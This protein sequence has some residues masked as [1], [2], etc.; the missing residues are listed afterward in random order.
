MK[1]P[2]ELVT[3]SGSSLNTFKLII[4]GKYHTHLV[5]VTVCVFRTWFVSAVTHKCCT[6]ETW[7]EIGT[8]HV[9]THKYIHM[10]TPFLL[11]S[12][13]LGFDYSSF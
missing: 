9:C 4:E 6:A 1:H 8:V 12:D 10:Y 3:P 7:V 5:V 11:S 2:Y 13:N